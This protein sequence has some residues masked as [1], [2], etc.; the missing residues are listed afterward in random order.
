[1][2][3]ENLADTLDSTPSG[4]TT[5]TVDPVAWGAAFQSMEF[6]T[7]LKSVI[8]E[9]LKQSREPVAQVNHLK[10]LGDPA[11][12]FHASQS[13]VVRGL[14][15]PSQR[16]RSGMLNAPSF[17]QTSEAS[18]VN[19]QAIP[20]ANDQSTTNVRSP[21]HEHVD[22]P[23]TSVAVYKSSPESAFVLGPGRSPI[24]TKLVK[25]SYPTNISNCLN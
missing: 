5:T 17:I 21:L 1:M 18:D 14:E 19:P 16:P 3:S 12:T 7:G 13:E 8:S 6:V 20:L 11:R 24:P 2:A 4:S 25:K 22:P 10:Q 9:V 23:N 15:Q